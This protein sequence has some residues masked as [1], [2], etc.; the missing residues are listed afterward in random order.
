M[1]QSIYAQS[2]PQIY[3]IGMRIA[4]DDRVFRYCKAK[5]AL[6]PLMDGMCGHL[7]SVRGNTDAVIYAAGTYEIT[8]PMNS[9]SVDYVAEQTVNYW[10]GG[11]IWIIPDPWSPQTTGVGQFYR[12][13]SSAVA[14]GGFVTVTLEEPLIETVTASRE[15]NVWPNIYSKIYG[16]PW[17]FDGK[18]RTSL[19]CLPLIPVTLGN[20]FWGQ[21]WGPMM[22]QCGFTPGRAEHDREVYW[23]ADHYGFVPGTEVDFTTPNAI[24]QRVGFVLTNTLPWTN[25]AGAGQLGS[26]NLIMLQLSP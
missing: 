15:V 8:I 24:P 17:P 13:K 18:A 12:I 26:D 21:T 19:V 14:V 23:K 20:H 1:K 22:A 9:H 3:P 2:T 10:A 25:M 16:V 5:T 6:R 4:L 11:W 7:V